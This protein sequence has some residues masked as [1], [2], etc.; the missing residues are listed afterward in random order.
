MALMRRVPTPVHSQEDADEQIEPALSKGAKADGSGE[1]AGQIHG[2]GTAKRLRRSR[3]LAAYLTT[4]G[5]QE[6]R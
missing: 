3:V 5:L 6:Q 4:W 2:S 1:G